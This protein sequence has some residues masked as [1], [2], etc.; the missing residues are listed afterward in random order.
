MDRIRNIKKPKMTENIVYFFN[1]DYK[2][3]L[4]LNEVWL[5]NGMIHQLFIYMSNKIDDLMITSNR[6]EIK[7]SREDD[8]IYLDLTGFTEETRFELYLDSIKEN[9]HRTYYATTINFTSLK[10]VFGEYQMVGNDKNILSITDNG[11]GTIKLKKLFS[12]QVFYFEVIDFD[13][14]SLEIKT[15]VITKI[16]DKQYC[17]SLM[18][19]YYSKS[20][21][22]QLF[23]EDYLNGESKIILGKEQAVRFDK[24][25][26]S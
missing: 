22:A 14:H 9:I 24:K 12:E 2:D 16:N 20:I 25:E 18:Y 26:S 13:K 7:I 4:L 5:M 23:E 17:L 11:K 15:K 8:F 6:E 10:D 19:D 21:F 1:P 3:K